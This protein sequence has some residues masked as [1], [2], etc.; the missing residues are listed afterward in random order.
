[1]FESES[2]QEKL[3]TIQLDVGYK[4]T[5]YKMSLC[6]NYKCLYDGD[7]HQFTIKY[8]MY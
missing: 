3:M 6:C 4:K 7:E 2:F 1:M 8:P 5:T